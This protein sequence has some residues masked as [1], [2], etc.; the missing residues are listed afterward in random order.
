MEQIGKKGFQC[1]APVM[2]GYEPS[3]ISHAH[4]L[5]VVDLVDDIL[6]W[7]ED[8][9][10][11]SVHLVGHNWG[12]VIAFAAGMY[13]P[14]RILGLLLLVWTNDTGAYLTGRKWGKYNL[15]QPPKV[16]L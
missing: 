4:K 15:T 1:I 10:W 5:H 2:R 14:N 7:M 12:S 8:R 16:G 13:Y 3:T 11:D 6:G 9:R